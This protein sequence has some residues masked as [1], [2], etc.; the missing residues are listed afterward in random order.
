M[1][2]KIKTHLLDCTLRDGSYENNFGFTKNDTFNICKS[3][4]KAGVKYI[5][6]GHGLGLGATN[7]TKFK[8]ITA[9][10]NYLEATKKAVKS[11]KW[12]MFCIPGIA[13][14]DD[15]KMAADY[16]MKFVRVGTNL[17]DHKKAE[18]FV[19]LAKKLNLFVCS[20]YM[21]TYLVSPK[22]FIKYV[23]FSK[24]IGS[25]LVYIVDSAG[26]MFPEE[27]DSYYNQIK[28][29]KIK[30]KLG[31]HGH[32]NLCMA[33]SN[34]L[35]AI[36]LGFEL[37]DCSLQGF[38]R[39]A[40][41][42]S[43]EQ[44]VCSLIRKNKDIGINPIEIMNISEKYIYKLIKK[45]GYRPIDVVSGLTLFHS[46]YMPIIIKM[47]KKYKIDPRELIIALTNIDRSQVDKE[48][49]EKESL[50][51]KKRKHSGNWKKI[52]GNYYGQEQ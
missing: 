16:G 8:A 13:K 27:L 29:E 42:A 9:D 10:K 2:K 1:L 40:G 19:K 52:Y 26:G 23:R 31:F 44:L 43:S 36:E 39:S 20:N 17:E 28:L 25:D 34:S 38:G 11:A 7:S 30:I 51:L 12:G 46:S 5:E 48:T 21:K 3:L 41:N 24:N 47:A 22:K 33:V 4:E 18:P 45:K 50:K 14:L 49:A 15:L 37:V 35:K 6:V 32:N